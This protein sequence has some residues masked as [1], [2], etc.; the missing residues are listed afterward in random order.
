M[1][2]SRGYAVRWAGGMCAVLFIGA[3][4]VLGTMAQRL[5]YEAGTALSWDQI[6]LIRWCVTGGVWLMGLAIGAAVYLLG[7]AL[8]RVDVLEEWVVSLDTAVRNREM[9]G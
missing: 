3:G 5:L 9:N 6:S 4:N 2:K 1:K 7:A 8:E